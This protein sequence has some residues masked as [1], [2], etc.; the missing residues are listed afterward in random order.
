MSRPPRGT[1][2]GFSGMSRCRPG[3]FPAGGG[4]CAPAPAECPPAPACPYPG[5][6][7][8][9]PSPPGRRHGGR[10]Q[11]AE[12]PGCPLCG[13]KSRTGPC[14]RPPPGRHP[15]AGPGR[16]RPPA[17]P[18]GERPAPGT[19]AGQRPRPG[20]PW[21]AGRGPDG[22]PPRKNPGAWWPDSAAGTRSPAP[23]TRPPAWCRRRGAACPT[24]P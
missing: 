20:L 17:P 5:P 12:R 4:R 3:T 13:G 8:A 15:A 9:A 14:V 10:W 19:A 16:A 6:G 21:A 2:R 22:P 7:S 11:C 23:R 18:S 24:A 1:G